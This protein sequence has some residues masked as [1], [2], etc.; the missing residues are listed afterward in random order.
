MTIGRGGR[1]G[2]VKY[3]PDR[4]SWPAMASDKRRITQRPHAL[5]VDRKLRA[6]RIRRSTARRQFEDPWN[7]C[8]RSC[9]WRSAGGDARKFAV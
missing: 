1:M 4:T 2:A 5:S 8:D 9:C 7:A 6:L 3:G